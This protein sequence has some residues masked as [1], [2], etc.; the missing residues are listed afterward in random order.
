VSPHIV[1]MSSDPEDILGKA[2]ALMGRHRPARAGAE[3]YAEIPVLSEVV[4]PPGG[5]DDLPVLTELVVPEPADAAHAGRRSALEED[6]RASLLT[7][8]QPEIDRLIENRLKESLSPL[9]ERMFNELRGDLQAI[10]REILSDA[11]HSAVEE[12]LERRK[13]VG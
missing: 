1:N 10:A 11:I 8:L 9:V 4:A 5:S 6:I 7:E 3:P 13:S 2:D 12:E